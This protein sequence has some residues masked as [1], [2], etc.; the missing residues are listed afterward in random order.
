MNVEEVLSHFESVRQLGDHW[1]ARCPAHEDRNPSLDIREKGGKILLHCHADCPV[2]RVL[3]EAGLKIS[4]LFSD[5][6][7]KQIV[8]TYDYCDE[9]GTLLYQV[10]RREPKD[11]LQRRP[12][13]NGGWIP[14]VKGVRRV[15]YRLPEVL[16]AKSVLVVEG[17]KDADTGSTLG[18]TA[19]CNAGGAGKW[20]DEYSE[21]LR[22][23]R[24][25][26]IA[27]ADE[28]GRKHTR[29]VAASLTGK[30]ESL[31][32][33]ELSGAKD[34]SEWIEKGG[35]RERLVELIR[36]APPW[37]PE[38][39]APGASLVSVSIAEL[40]EREIKPREML[41]DPILPEQGLA[42]L[43][44]YR[45]I[46]KTFIALGVAAAVASGGR[47]L[48]WT[49]PR[50]RRVLYLDGELPAKTIQERTAMVLAGI[51]GD[52]P[53][54]NALRI[55]TPDFQERPIPDLSTLEGQRLIEP[56]LD[57]IDLLVLDNLSAL[58]RYGNENEGESW[59]PVQEWGLS[60]RRRGIS[61]LF[62]HHAGKNKS[63][64]GTS[65]RE[66]LLDTVITL[67]HPPDYNPS[68]GLRS[69]VHFEKTRGMLAEGAKPFEV[70]LETGEDG[71][72]VW[73]MRD[74]EDAK[75]AQAA[76]LFAAG[77]S[78][79]DVAEELGIS[80]SSAH[81][82]RKLSQAGG[83]AEVSQRPDHIGVG[84]WDS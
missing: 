49:A 1:V 64:R 78:V 16:K 66:D 58:C 25:V 33:I 24:V 17:E 83:N 42:M 6:C 37:E 73:T 30:V 28:P 11:F 23:K 70:R 20:R 32:V 62:I 46:G 18:L 54:P 69:E 80:R 63:Q 76:E 52:D 77:M 14:N 12:D 19:T 68:E 75:A 57:G 34:L 39:S 45:G 53:A 74:L 59:L 67:K 82:L 13:G 60:L 56:H 55:I 41:L 38:S 50:A 51:E 79:R 9:H 5:L 71:R 48:R 35:T 61:V 26:I 44:A 47:F 22:G 10:V 36:N 40:L 84:Q 8:A 4:D 81:R 43:Y 65:R 27:D 21:K 2:E 29:Q 7:H 3:E 31:K 15:L 72:A